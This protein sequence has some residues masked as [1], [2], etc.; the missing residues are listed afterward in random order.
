M[1]FALPVR[2]SPFVTGLS[3]AANTEARAPLEA[4]TVGRVALTDD[5]VSF[6]PEDKLRSMPTIHH[7][8]HFNLFLYTSHHNPLVPL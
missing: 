3:E 7:P 8:F 4:A 1:E 5:R 6:L 2:L